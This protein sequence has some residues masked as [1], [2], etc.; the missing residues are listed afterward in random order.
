MGAKTVSNA[1]RV[2]H[3]VSKISKVVVHLSNILASGLSI[4]LGNIVKRALSGSRP[5]NNDNIT[6]L[7]IKES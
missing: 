5:I 3:A 2:A 6:V 4:C 1:V 7:L